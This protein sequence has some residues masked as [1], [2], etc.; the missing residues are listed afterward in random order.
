[1]TTESTPD[2]PTGMSPL[3]GAVAAGGLAVVV[4]ALVAAVADGRAGVVGAAAGG[5]LTLVVFALGIL[6][7]GLVA[8]VMP[9]ASLLVALMTYALQLLALALVVAAIERAGWDA[10]TLSRGWFAAGVIAVTLLWLVGQLVA[11]TR[12]RIPSYDGVPTGGAAQHPGG[13]R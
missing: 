13:E 3:L 11:A 9:S 4:L 12:Q 2:F 1:M 7:V 6:V 10:T 5:V 8:R